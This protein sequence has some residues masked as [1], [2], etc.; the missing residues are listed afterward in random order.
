MIL[1]CY[2]EAVRSAI[3][4]EAKLIETKRGR[5]TGRRLMEANKDQE[6]LSR[7]CK[8]IKSLFQQLQVRKLG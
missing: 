5:G 4:E 8:R 2:S 1:R 3:E 6:E 7:Y